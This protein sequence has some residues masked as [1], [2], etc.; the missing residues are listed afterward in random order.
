MASSWRH[1]VGTSGPGSTSTPSQKRRRDTFPSCCR[2]FTSCSWSTRCQATSSS[3]S[4]RA[5]P[6][7]PQPSLRGT[8][9]LSTPSRTSRRFCTRCPRRLDPSDPRRGAE[10]RET[11]LR[12]LRAR[13]AASEKSRPGFTPS[14]AASRPWAR[15]SPRRAPSSRRRR[16][17]GRKH[18]AALRPI[19]APLGGV[20]GRGARPRGGS[21][22]RVDGEP[23]G[24]LSRVQPPRRTRMGGFGRHR[25]GAP[26]RPEA[27]RRSQFVGR[28]A[29]HGP[30]DPRAN[31]IPRGCLGG[32]RRPSPS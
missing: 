1:Q 13:A 20:A 8:R 16:G 11:L 17:G 21:V 28:R 14:P 19:P 12:G 9:S 4:S 22:S 26:L 23:A 24:R 18:R 6:R 5:N 10:V 7:R 2:P 27:R 25:S 30:R 32:H 29:H 31:I 15:R 3:G